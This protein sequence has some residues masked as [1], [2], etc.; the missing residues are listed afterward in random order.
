MEKKGPKAFRKIIYRD[1]GPC[2]L[3]SMP[4]LKS[5]S[6]LQIKQ[7]PVSSSIIIPAGVGSLPDPPARNDIPPN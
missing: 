5:N 4:A 2:L 6:R 1:Y 3:I 7:F